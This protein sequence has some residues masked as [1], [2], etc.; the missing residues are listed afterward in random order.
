[1]RTRSARH[2]AVAAVAALLWAALVSASDPPVPPGYVRRAP[3]LQCNRAL[4]SRFVALCCVCAVLYR[5]V[6]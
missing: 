3:V 4:I 6:R 5:V 1:M 2:V